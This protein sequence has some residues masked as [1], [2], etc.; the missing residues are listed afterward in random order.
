MN[1]LSVDDS[2]TIRKLVRNALDMLGH[3]TLEAENGQA[4]L[5]ALS[6]NSDVGLILMDWDMP[7]MDG[8]SAVKAIKEN[9][10]L[11][12]IPIIMLTAV[13]EPDKIIEAIGAGATN[14]IMK[15][16]TQEELMVKIMECLDS[17]Q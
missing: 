12:N 14:Y 8:L 1:I 17:E 5:D 11:S 16:F 9:E 4:A 7:V 3:N 15:P 10:S 2:P 6:N 13:N